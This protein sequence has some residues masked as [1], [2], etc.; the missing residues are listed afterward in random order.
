MRRSLTPRIGQSDLPANRLPILIRG[1]GAHSFHATTPCFEQPRRAHTEDKVPSSGRRGTVASCGSTPLHIRMRCTPFWSTIV[2]GA[3]RASL[4][5]TEV[6]DLRDRPRIPEPAHIVGLT[7]GDIDS[8]T[9]AGSSGAAPADDVHAVHPRC[10]S[11]KC[12]LA[13]SVA[14]P[15]DPISL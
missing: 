1:G 10:S 3:V 14:K 9:Y 8:T 15:S 5:S 6:Y 13:K 2:I 7:L 11:R 4:F 12:G